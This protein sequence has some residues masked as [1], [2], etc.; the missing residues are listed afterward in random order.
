MAVDCSRVIWASSV[1]KTQHVIGRRPAGHHSDKLVKHPTV[2]KTLLELPIIASSSQIITVGVSE[3]V[4]RTGTRC[5]PASSLTTLLFYLLIYC[6][7]TF[8]SSAW[9]LLVYYISP[10]QRK[11]TLFPSTSRTW[12]AL[13]YSDVQAKTWKMMRYLVPEACDQKPLNCPLMNFTHTLWLLCI[14]YNT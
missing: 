3:R 2:S 7:P 10:T 9:D 4:Q 12:A 5:T 14:L 13:R 1:N 6:P 8:C 11:L